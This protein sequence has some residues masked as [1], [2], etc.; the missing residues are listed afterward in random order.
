MAEIKNLDGTTVKTEQEVDTSTQATEQTS[1]TE[2]DNNVSTTSDSNKK[3]EENKEPK[4]ELKYLDKDFVYDYMSVPT[5]SREEFRAV[6]YIALWAK[7]NEVEFE[8]DKKGNI[9]LTKGVLDEGEYYPCLTSHLDTVQDKQ[10]PYAKA[11]VRLDV[12]TRINSKNQHEI[13][14]EGFGIGGDDKAGVTI[15]LNMFKYFDKIKACF[16]LEEEIGCL[17]S[18]ELKTEWFK[19]VGYVIGYDSPD[20]NRAARVCSGEKLFDKEFFETYMADT[21]KKWGLTD[22]RCEPFTDVVSIR[23][24]TD[25]ICMNFGTGYYN[26][27][28]ANEYCVLE[29][30][31]HA[32]GMG[33]EL[34][35]KI[36]NTLH[37]MKREGSKRYYAYGYGSSNEEDDYYDLFN[38]KTIKPKTTTNYSSYNYNSYGS[39][40]SSSNTKKDDNPDSI[41]FDELQYI[42]ERY[43]TKLTEI[44]EALKKKC[45]ELK[46][47]FEKEFGNIVEQEIKF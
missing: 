6:T 17:G 19:D 22:F 10:T 46:L 1:T 3:E 25:I 29:D 40:S 30:M 35:K 42:V 9:Y 7:R 41:S 14:C 44:K 4:L 5:H 26:C 24:K 11:G 37:E 39:G 38:G 15:C 43:E 23:E 36:G 20:L 13:Y 47:D 2:T 8:F 32:C 21:V 16:F 27:H 45:D 34:I 31:D 18:K 33:I 28:M 12:K